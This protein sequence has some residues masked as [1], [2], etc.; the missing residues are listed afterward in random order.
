MS[1]GDMISSPKMDHDEAQ[2][3]RAGALGKSRQIG[4]ARK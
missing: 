3:E 2:H 4:S 1:W